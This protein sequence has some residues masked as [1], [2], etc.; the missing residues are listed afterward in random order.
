MRQLMSSGTLDA[1][2]RVERVYQWYHGTVHTSSILYC[3]VKTSYKKVTKRS[4]R[5]RYIKG[6]TLNVTATGCNTLNKQGGEKD[7]GK[8]GLGTKVQLL[9]YIL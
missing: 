4:R 5:G 1:V 8:A 3:I 7:V 9:N 6:N 2:P